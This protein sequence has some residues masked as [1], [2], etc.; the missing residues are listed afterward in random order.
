[1]SAADLESGGSKG[2]DSKKA[3]S[4]HWSSTDNLKSP[5]PGGNES[6]THVQTHIN[7]SKIANPSTVGLFSFALPTIL[8][9]IY[10]CLENNYNVAQ[11]NT[12]LMFWFAG[13][14][15]F[16]AGLLEVRV[17]FIIIIIIIIIIIYIWGSTNPKYV[18]FSWVS[19]L[20]E[21][22]SLYTLFS[23]FLSVQ[24]T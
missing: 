19:S 17:L 24:C 9:G 22:F 23:G 6:C 14:G 4:Q 15:Q 5:I 3:I 11:F 13:I 2:I 7:I 18:S 12:S 1:M 16:T 10:G 21:L 8:S 20:V